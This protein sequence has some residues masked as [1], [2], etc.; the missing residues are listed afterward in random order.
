MKL[1][2]KDTAWRGQMTTAGNSCLA[3]TSMR[4]NGCGV[5]VGVARCGDCQ[6][7]EYCGTACQ[8]R[9]WHKHRLL[10]RR[11]QSSIGHD[12]TQVLVFGLFDLFNTDVDW[13]YEVSAGS[14]GWEVCCAVDG[15]NARE[16]T[17]MRTSWCPGYLGQDSY[18]RCCQ[19]KV[20][21]DKWDRTVGL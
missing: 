5:K 9:D 10:C 15:N 6:V 2:R 17:I 4:C 16:S 8:R 19:S 11:L 13:E 18:R 12:P 14:C 7:T 21:K 1:R 3:L 20:P